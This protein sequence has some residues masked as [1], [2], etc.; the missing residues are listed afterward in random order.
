ML[1]NVIYFPG[2]TLFQ[3]ALSDFQ[4]SRIKFQKGEISRGQHKQGISD[5]LAYLQ[6]SKDIL[7][8]DKVI[9]QNPIMYCMILEQVDVM[10]DTL[11]SLG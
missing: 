1:Y 7:E 2:V 5:I 8:L 4:I 9:T 10:Q 3:M 6:T 11:N